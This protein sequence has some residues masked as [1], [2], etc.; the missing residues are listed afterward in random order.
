MFG[1]KVALSSV[2]TD[3]VM[4]FLDKSQNS[5]LLQLKWNP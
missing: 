3:V 5:R 2:A 4:T 1:M